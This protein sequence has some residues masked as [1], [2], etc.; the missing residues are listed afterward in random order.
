MKKKKVKLELHRET[1]R[2][3][4]SQELQDVVGAQVPAYS[5][6]PVCELTDFTQLG[7]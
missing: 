1:L 5:K 2:R 4:D 7:C 6:P 3:L